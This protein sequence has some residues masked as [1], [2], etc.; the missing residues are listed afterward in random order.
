VNEGESGR[1]SR[2]T[3]KNCAW[4]Y[5]GNSETANK[6]VDLDIRQEPCQYKVPILTTTSQ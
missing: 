3:Q 2:G 5:G 4:I 6:F 1:W